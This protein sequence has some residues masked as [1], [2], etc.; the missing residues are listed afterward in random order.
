MVERIS[1]EG[2]VN[3]HP[4]YILDK[5]IAYSAIPENTKT[6]PCVRKKS[7]VFSL[8]SASLALLLSE[9]TYKYNQDTKTEKKYNLRRRE[10]DVSKPGV[11]RCTLH[12]CVVRHR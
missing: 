4:K 2:F 10:Y 6:T 11:V 1:N 3:I 7:D 12:P 5:Y 9:S 8:F